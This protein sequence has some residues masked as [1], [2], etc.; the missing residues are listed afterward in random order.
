MIVEHH[1]HSNEL[2][3]DGTHL[4]YQ[5]K[6]VICTNREPRF[7]KHFESIEPWK[8][9]DATHGRLVGFMRREMYESKGPF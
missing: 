8:I 1:W 2:N 9:Y 5:V 7:I 3:Q 6:F 4:V